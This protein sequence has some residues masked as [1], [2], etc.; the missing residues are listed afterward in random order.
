M[1]RPRM[2]KRLCQLVIYILHEP[3]TY[4]QSHDPGHDCCYRH[5]GSQFLAEDIAEGQL[6]HS[7]SAAM[8][9]GFDDLHARSLPSGVETSEQRGADCDA[10][11]VERQLTREHYFTTIAL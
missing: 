5:S 3:A 9:Q 2:D 11:R 6:E 1:A 8:A 7:K 10:Q 4:N